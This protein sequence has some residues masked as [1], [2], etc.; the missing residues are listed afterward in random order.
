MLQTL[1]QL[2][3]ENA[4][5]LAKNKA[6]AWEDVAKT[7]KAQPDMAGYHPKGRSC[8]L[9]FEELMKSSAEQM[10]EVWSLSGGY[11]DE[12]ADD[13]RRDARLDCWLD[14]KQKVDDAQ[15]SIRGP[16]SASFLYFQMPR[17]RLAFQIS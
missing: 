12:G 1:N 13:E 5:W 16:L 2:S 7:L 15:Q 4:P 14:L 11:A 9:R 3:D 6:H 17:A 10:C 8:Q